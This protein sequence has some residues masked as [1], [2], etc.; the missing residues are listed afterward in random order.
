MDRKKSSESNSPSGSQLASPLQYLPTG[1]SLQAVGANA[2][3]M[4]FS[5]PS[6]HGRGAAV[7][8]GQ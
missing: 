6:G 5:V 7:L 2:P 8:A 3:S 1:H 4:V